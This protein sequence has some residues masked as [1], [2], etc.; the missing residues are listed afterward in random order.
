M[1]IL[2]DCLVFDEKV[3]VNELESC[4]PAAYM[5]KKFC[6][7]ENFVALKISEKFCEIVHVFPLNFSY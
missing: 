6:V 1:K 7:A 3:K 5:A 2:L 4:F